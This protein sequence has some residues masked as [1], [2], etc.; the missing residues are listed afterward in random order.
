MQKEQDVHCPACG[1]FRGRKRK[2]EERREAR[3]KVGEGHFVGVMIRKR[4]V[5]HR[6]GQRMPG[7]AELE[8]YP[9]ASG[10]V[11]CISRCFWLKVPITFRENALPSWILA[12]FEEHP[13]L[14]EL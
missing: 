8:I 11:P 7:L 12:Q 1:L 14:T 4:P 9:E 5:A 2:E 6:L 13:R 10:R 3:R